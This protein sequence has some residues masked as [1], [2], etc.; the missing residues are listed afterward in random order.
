MRT[1]SQS[2]VDLYLC[3]ALCKSKHV[4][5]IKLSEVYQVLQALRK[6]IP[7]PENTMIPGYTDYEW[8]VKTVDE[9]ILRITV[10]HEDY[11]SWTQDEVSIVPIDYIYSG[12]DTTVYGF[13]D[14]HVDSYYGWKL[15]KELNMSEQYREQIE[16]FHSAYM[17]F[18]NAVAAGDKENAVMFF[19]EIADAINTMDRSYP[20]LNILMERYGN[21]LSLLRSLD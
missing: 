9:R 6:Y 15:L 1:L 10:R 17:N 7:A 12:D 4:Y 2:G 5:D 16:V 8:I 18:S 20:Y 3:Y 13:A 14:K 21:A 19:N 11:S